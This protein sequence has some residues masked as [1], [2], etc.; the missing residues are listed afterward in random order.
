MSIVV[1]GALLAGLPL[2]IAFDSWLLIQTHVSIL[3]VLTHVRADLY[4]L[5]VLVVTAL[6]GAAVGLAAGIYS[7]PAWISFLISTRILWLRGKLP[8]RTR[9]F[10]DDAHR[11]GL[12]RTAGM[13]YQLRHA[14]LQDRL[15]PV[16]AWPDQRR[17]EE[18]RLQQEQRQRELEYQEH[19]RIAA[20]QTA[21]QKKVRL[22]LQL[23]Y[24]ERQVATYSTISFRN[25]LKLAES[26]EGLA[27]VHRQLGNHPAA[28]AAVD[29]EIAIRRELIEDDDFD[30]E[31][32][33][34]ALAQLAVSRQN[35]GDTSGMIV[36][37]TESVE[38][39]RELTVEASVL[40]VVKL[41]DATERLLDYLA[42]GEGAAAAADELWL[43]SI[44]AVDSAPAE[45]MLRVRY[46]DW[47]FRHDK[48]KSALEQ[49]FRA[50]DLILGPDEV[51]DYLTTDLVR[52]TV[53][54]TSDLRRRLEPPTTA[55]T[56]TAPHPAK[57][58][59][60]RSAKH[61]KQ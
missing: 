3:D 6:L 8:W 20:E 46:G 61:R 39:W 47:L 26:L 58:S 33:A 37:A 48:P 31:H 51:D 55:P 7:E 24:W 9:S 49:L 10:L 54:R 16:D 36:A 56:E 59:G 12:L 57:R 53:D 5:S 25:P 42:D 38:L 34:D 52:S 18:Y 50:E 15:A 19:Q 13:V 11:I 4:L 29:R 32:L 17:A 40:Y 14:E 28:C 2:G 41:C 43:E 30:K 27:T 22:S 35:A 1:Y 23:A 44:A 60:G 21:E 45:S